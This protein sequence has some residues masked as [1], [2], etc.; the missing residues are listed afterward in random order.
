MILQGM[1]TL[2]DK[3]NKTIFKHTQDLLELQKNHDVE[4][5]NLKNERRAV[6]LFANESNKKNQ[7]Q[8]LLEA[9]ENNQILKDEITKMKDFHILR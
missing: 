7:S 2:N 4:V 6:T 5:Q 8:D 1:E 3:L 9:L